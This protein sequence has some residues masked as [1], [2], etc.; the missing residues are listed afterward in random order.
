MP[1]I[2]GRTA[3]EWTSG[4][5]TPFDKA[6]AI[7][8]R[9]RS[10]D[11]SYTTKVQ[12]TLGDST[13]VQSVAAFLEQRAGYCVHFASTMAVLAR[14]SEGEKGAHEAGGQTSTQETTRDH[15]YGRRKPSRRENVRR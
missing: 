4:A 9:L 8:N 15:L 7:Q 13:G 10:S 5:S 1:N 14:E 11:F 12:D 2:V 6:I 3:R